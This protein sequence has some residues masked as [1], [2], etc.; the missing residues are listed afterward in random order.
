MTSPVRLFVFG[1]GYTAGALARAMLDRADWVGGTVRTVDKAVT[2]AAEGLRTFIFDGGAPGVGVAE[3]VRHATHLVVSIPPG[4][5]DPVLACHRESV[6]AAVHL[7]WIGYLST[8]GVYGDHDGAWVDEDTPP[9]PKRGRSAERFAAEH[10]WQVVAAERGIPLAVFRI[11]GIYGPG[12]N[13]FV[14]LAEGTARR[15]VKPDQV[16]NR[17]HIDDIVQVLESAVDN[18][19]TGIFNLA[20]DEPAPPQDVIAHAC[21]LMGVPPPPEVAFDEADLSEMARSFYGDNKR[22]SNRRIKE[23]LGVT[24]RY[25]TYRD[26]LAALWKEG[27]WR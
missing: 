17:I 15:V 22:V 8:V 20:D 16:F 3:A 13:A 7:R 10:A 2:L 12:R 27:S 25:P 21:G 18:N 5:T 9:E 14:K 11:A 23:V 24:L 26:G 1:L 6:L 19:A 4:R